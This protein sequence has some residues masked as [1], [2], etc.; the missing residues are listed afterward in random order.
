MH[1]II[2][3]KL[4]MPL[5]ANN[6][7]DSSAW[8]DAAAVSF[9]EDWCG[10][11]KDPQRETQVRML[12][13]WDSLFI[14][15]QCRYRELYTYEDKDNRR[16]QLWMRDVAEIFLQTGAD[17]FRTYKEFEISPNGDWLDLHIAPG[18]KT[19]LFWNIESR[20]T[21]NPATRIWTAEMSIPM[22]KLTPSFHPREIWKLN[23]FR[24]EGAEPNRFY[25]SWQPTYTDKPN[26]HVPECFGELVFS[27]GRE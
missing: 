10:K 14:Q 11:N 1:R 3:E 26:F 20:V 5:S 13:S 17:E 18:Q 15:F 9:C 16:D 27:V 2:A 4:S 7:P 24:I 19:D 12:W 25:S 22:Q 6:L 23:L 8:N 21:V